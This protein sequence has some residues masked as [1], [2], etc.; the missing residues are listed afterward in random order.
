VKDELQKLAKEAGP[1]IAAEKA[2]KT[3]ALLKKF[4][5]GVVALALIDAA[6]GLTST[7]AQCTIPDVSAEAHLKALAADKRFAGMALSVKAGNAHSPGIL[8]VDWS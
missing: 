6:K 1:K 8:T 4:V 5:E 2:A 3:D 7:R